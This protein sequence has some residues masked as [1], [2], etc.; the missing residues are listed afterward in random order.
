MVKHTVAMVLVLAGV[1]APAT[2]WAQEI[3]SDDFESR[4]ICFWSNADHTDDD[5]D[6][7]KL[8]HFDCDDGDPSINPGKTDTCGDGVD[9]DCTGFADESCCHPL[10]QNCQDGAAACYYNLLNHSFVCGT[11]FGNPPGQQ[12][13]PCDF[14]NACDEGFG[15]T[16]CLPQNCDAENLLCAAYC[17]PDLNDCATGE[18]CLFYDEFWGDVAPAPNDFGMCVPNDS[19]P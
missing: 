2:T 3:F 19:I 4:G 5:S 16:L 14:V 8:C 18:T 9:S 1:L 12:D 13:D 11:P 6:G 17:D 15:C 7:Y 10:L